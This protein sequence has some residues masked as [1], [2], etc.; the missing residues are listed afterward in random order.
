MTTGGGCGWFYVNKK[1]R[2][3]GI[4]E[5]TRKKLSIATTRRNIGSKKSEETKEK[6]RRAKKNISQETR[7]KMSEA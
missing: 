6:I 2:E 4:S 1:N 3:E 7:E 5:E